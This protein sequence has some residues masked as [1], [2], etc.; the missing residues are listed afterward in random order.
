NLLNRGGIIPTKVFYKLLIRTYRSWVAEIKDW[1][2]RIKQCL[3]LADVNFYCF[4][5]TGI[6]N[7]QTSF[8]SNVLTTAFNIFPCTEIGSYC[9]TSL[10]NPR[11]YP[12]CLRTCSGPVSDLVSL[13]RDTA[14]CTSRQ[15]NSVA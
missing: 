7:Y 14:M 2:N 15:T 8:F 1:R 9:P 13:N 12:S 4:F 11:I 10:S 5:S 6:V 3:P